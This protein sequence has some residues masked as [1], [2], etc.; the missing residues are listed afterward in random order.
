[1][2]RVNIFRVNEEQS[3]VDALAAAWQR[4]QRVDLEKEAVESVAVKTCDLERQEN[5]FLHFSSRALSASFS[6]MWRRCSPRAR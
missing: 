4:G 6:A 2:F 1:L 3:D 5:I